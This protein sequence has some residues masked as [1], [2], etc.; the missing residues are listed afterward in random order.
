MPVLTTVLLWL[1]SSSTIAHILLHRPLRE[2]R[3]WLLKV[4]Y[5]CILVRGDGAGLA[6]DS[7][8]VEG[9]GGGVGGSHCCAA[10]WGGAGVEGLEEGRL[11]GALVS[12]G[13]GKER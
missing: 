1:F 8:F 5:L 2:A 9:I 11:V 13:E 3:A 4:L 12:V 10:F 7:V 6:E